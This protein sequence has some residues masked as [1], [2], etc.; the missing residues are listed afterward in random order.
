MTAQLIRTEHGED[1]VIL[2]KSEYEA[3]LAKASD[4]AEDE[5]DCALFDERMAELDAGAAI[6]L[7]EAV[8]AVMLRGANILTATRKWKKI[9]QSK[10]A[11]SAGI[12][13][14]YL[15]DLESGR[16]AGTP[17]TLGKLAELLSVPPAWFTD[18]A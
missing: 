1:L 8:S 10:L 16:R 14:G 7:P 4:A 6:K 18:A 11:G 13:Q 12:A 9:S 3:L 15:A 17:E 2:P 5:A